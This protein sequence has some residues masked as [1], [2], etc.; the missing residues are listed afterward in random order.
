MKEDRAMGDSIK[1]RE[2]LLVRLRDVQDHESWRIFY[3]R[4]WELL[5]NV[6]RQSGLNEPDAEDVVQETVIGVARAIPE[7]RYDRSRGSFKQWML[8]IVRRRIV[9][10]LR[11]LYRQPPRAEL[12][13]EEL[14]E[15]NAHA[16]SLHDPASER[17]ELAWER[18]WERCVLAEAIRRVKQTANPKHFQIFD[19]CVLKE[20]RTARTAATLE[21]SAAQ[22]YLARHRVSQ[23]V[24]REARRVHEEWA[25]GQGLG[26]GSGRDAE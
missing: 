5:Y 4:Y 17:I 3:D 18:E 20:W 1:T 6:A 11:R 25:A 12:L 16:P 7:F 8:R 2:T 10:Q 19:F 14:E 24:K 23:A 13:P 21:L 22:V 9:D 15:S 26:E